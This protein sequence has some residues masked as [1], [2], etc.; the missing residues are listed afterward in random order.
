M[1]EIASIDGQ[2]ILPTLVT[3]PSIAPYTEFEYAQM[4][5]DKWKIGKKGK[6]NGVIV[7]LAVR[8]RRWRIQTGYGVEGILTDALCSRIGR[9]E[10]VPYF[11]QGEYAQGLYSGVLAIAR[12]ISKD[13][14]I[15]LNGLQGVRLA[16][17]HQKVPIV[18]Y[19]FAF[20]FFL[21][22]NI[23]WPIFIGLPFTLIFGYAFYQMSPVLGF[24]VLA[25]YL[26]SMVLR[27]SITPDF[28][29]RITMISRGVENGEEKINRN[30]YIPGIRNSFGSIINDTNF[31]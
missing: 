14:G 27:Y 31:F 4:L 18:F 7:L 26:G 3:V 10:I 8:E 21:V 22:W 16:K 25:G 30:N 2:N 13:A 28:W 20:F 24:L 19:F 29:Y 6:D 9:N 23:P 15:S 17:P 12:L 5:F 1:D 11:K